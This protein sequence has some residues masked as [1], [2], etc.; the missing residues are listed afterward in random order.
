MWERDYMLLRLNVGGGQEWFKER[1]IEN[2]GGALST[3]S[4]GV[5]LLVWRHLETF[6]C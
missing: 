6:L 3:G 2:W 1:T 4:W 5:A